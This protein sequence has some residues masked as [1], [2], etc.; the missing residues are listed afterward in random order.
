MLKM[1][2]LHKLVHSLYYRKFCLNAPKV[3]SS[4]TDVYSNCDAVIYN[5]FALANWFVIV[6]NKAT[7][8]SLSY[9]LKIL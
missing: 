6:M 4:K 2:M 3:Y 5:G 9:H 8:H 7:S 1:I